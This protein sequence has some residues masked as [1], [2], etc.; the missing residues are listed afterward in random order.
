MR[1]RKLW[2]GE[3]TFRF[4]LR[5]KKTTFF[6]TSNTPYYR[7][8]VVFLFQMSGFHCSL[9]DSRVGIGY[10]RLLIFLSIFWHFVPKLLRQKY[11]KT[12]NYAELRAGM[13]IVFDFLEFINDIKSIKKMSSLKSILNKLNKFPNISVN[14]VKKVKIDRPHYEN[15]R[16]GSFCIRFLNCETTKL[17]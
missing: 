6:K 5:F 17:C 11:A 4:M 2:N 14:L 16:T 13:T 1:T 7:F 8:H 3:T 12:E 15:P 9:H 10:K